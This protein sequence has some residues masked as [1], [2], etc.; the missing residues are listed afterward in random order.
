M[1]PL[2]YLLD[3]NIIILAVE[4]ADGK[5]LERLARTDPEKLVTSVICLAEILRGLNG[6]PPRGYD[7]LLSQMNVSPFNTDAARQY[8][9]LPFKRRSFDRLIGAHTLA[10]GATLVTAD[11]SDFADI[12]GL[13]IEDWTQ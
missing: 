4:R 6:N 12:P 11:M 3:T 5:V 9:T 7:M 1:M 8:A 2:L 13:D 10:L